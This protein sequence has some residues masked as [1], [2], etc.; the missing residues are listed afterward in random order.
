MKRYDSYKDSGVK[1]LGEIPS[2][3]EMLPGLAVLKENKNKNTD[4]TEKTVLS[5]SYG[6][7]IIKKDIDEGAY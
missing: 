5:L 6:N 3:W 1:W 7:I 2:H 4:L